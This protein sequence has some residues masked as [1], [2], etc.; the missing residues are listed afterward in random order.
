MGQSKQRFA[1]S[2]K[3]IP[4]HHQ[5]FDNT[6]PVGDIPRQQSQRIGDKGGNGNDDPQFVHPLMQYHHDK[7]GQ[8]G[9]DHSRSHV[10]EKTHPPQHHHIFVYV[11]HNTGISSNDF[12]SPLPSIETT[13]MAGIPSFKS[14]SALSGLRCTAK[15]R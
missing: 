10:S 13:P 12:G 14:G 11:F 2:R 3:R 7:N 6:V 4:S 1:Q 9:G 15:T 8:Y 5:R